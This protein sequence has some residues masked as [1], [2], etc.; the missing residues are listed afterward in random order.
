MHLFATDVGRTVPAF[1][2]PFVGVA[3]RPPLLAAPDQAL[4]F[5]RNRKPSPDLPP[6]QVIG[7]LMAALQKNSPVDNDGLTTVSGSFRR[8][9]RY[10]TSRHVIIVSI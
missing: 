9:A 1:A 2:H 6:D 3:T 8:R 10:V 5:W 4:E 7:L